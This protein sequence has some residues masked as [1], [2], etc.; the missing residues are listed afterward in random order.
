MRCLLWYHRISRAEPSFRKPLTLSF[1]EFLF[2]GRVGGRIW[3]ASE[4]RTEKKELWFSGSAFGF[5]LLLR[6]WLTKVVTLHLALSRSSCLRWM[7]RR[8]SSVLHPSMPILRSQMRGIIRVTQQW[9]EM[10]LGGKS[11][12]S[13]FLNARH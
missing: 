3:C 4:T 13:I 12:S 10:E 6:N 11:S 5:S 2:L 1:R 7:K 8:S 9:V